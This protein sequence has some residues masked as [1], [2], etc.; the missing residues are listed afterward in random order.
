MLRFDR[1]IG[2]YSCR[3]DLPFIRTRAVICGLDFPEFGLIWQTDTWTIL[4]R[5]FKL[6]RNSLENS[7]LKL[8][9]S[10]NK[11][12]LSLNLKHGIIQGKKWAQKYCLDHNTK[13]VLDTERLYNAIYKFQRNTKTS[14]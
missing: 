14:I 10:T 11:N 13:D 7:T 5:K 9:G 8:L 2:H 12:H 1:I 6:S 3:Y 4:K